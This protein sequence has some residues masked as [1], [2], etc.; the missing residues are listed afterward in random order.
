MEGIMMDNILTGNNKDL[1]EIILKQREG[2][3]IDKWEGTCLD[4]LYLIKERPDIANFAPGRIYN[5]IMK[6]GIEEVDESL[7]TRGY[8]DLV[9]YK[10]FDNRIYG[11]LEA[12]HDIMKFLKAA[13][14]RTETS[15]RILMMVGPVSSGKS[16]ISYWIKRGLEMDDVPVYTI[17]D[18]PLHEDPLHVIPITDRPYWNNIL[19]MKI[20]G[21]LC[22]VCLQRLK[23]EYSDERGN[24]RWEEVPVESF[25]FSEQERA[26]IGTF[27]PSDPKCVSGDTLLLSNL[28]ILEFSE[29][30]DNLKTEMGDS[31]VF[32]TVID[33]IK[34]IEKTSCFYNNGIQETLK[35][36]TKFGYEETLT[37][38]HP[39]LVLRDGT[40]Q[41]IKGKNLEEGDYI[42]LKRGQMMFGSNDDLP[43]FNYNGP[44]SRGNNV[45]MTF[46]EKLTPELSKIL[47]YLVSE[48]S[49][50]RYAMWFS[51]MNKRLIDDFNY[52]FYKVFNVMPKIYERCS[53]VS[54]VKLCS[55]LDNVCSIKHYSENKDI[56]LIIRRASKNNVLSFLEGLFWGDGT[57]STRKSVKSNR[58]KYGSKSEKLIKQ[59]QVILLN[60]GIVSSKG[61]VVSKDGFVNYELIVN[62]D[63]VIKLIDLIPSLRDKKTDDGN[64]ID[65]RENS[66]WDVLPNMQPI[67]EEIVN[68]V[69]EKKGPIYKLSKISKLNRYKSYSEHGRFPR[70]STVIQIVNEIE[71]MGLDFMDEVSYLKEIANS[72]MVWLKLESIEDGGYQQVYDITVPRTHSFCANGF[73][74]HNS[75]DVSELIGRVNMALIS[76]YGEDDPRGYNFNGEL[77]VANRGIIEY[78]EILKADAKLHYVLITLAQEQLI[79][80]PG[81][82]QMYIDSLIIS[83][84]NQTEFDSFRADKKNEALHDRIYEVEVPLNVRINDEVKIYEKMIRE[85]DF[86]DIHIAPHTLRIA[87]EFAVLSRLVKST[88][89]SSLVEKMK[90]YNG[91]R[92]EEFAKQ[93]VDVKSLLQEGKDSGEGMSG[94]SP[95]FIINALNIALGMKESKKCINPID[96]IRALRANFD[97]HIGTSD[98]DKERFTNI[99]IGEKESVSSEFKDIAKKEVN[100]AFLYAYEEQ[101]QTLFEN[102]MKSVTSFC[103]KEKV[104]DSITGEYSDP[105][106]KLMRSIEELASVPVNSKAEFRNS[107]FVHKVDSLERGRSFTYKDYPI[108]KESVEKKLIGDLK[109]LVSLSL[110]DTTATD[111]KIKKRRE[112]ALERLM[113]TGHCESCANSILSFVAEILRREG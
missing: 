81:F 9:R 98:E 16:T 58:F 86:R 70:R 20:E 44:N 3:S 40:L 112:K 104:L 39:L 27:A 41:W 57:I 107:I 53:S 30:Q 99:L 26:G 43:I 71:K 32:E 18:C 50:D 103:K 15:K 93:E 49:H 5:M 101:A 69:R 56:P 46:P 60:M 106:E 108:L 113:E 102:Y 80:A 82:P 96:V 73:I 87:A 1:R 67:F 35:I 89:V 38:E 83:H 52:N 48:G 12:I 2:R 4:Y 76:K 54:S 66:N 62:G 31:C 79:K 33:G 59:L 42:T 61:T 77:Q 55:Y 23:K 78:I 37:K 17:K 105:D 90:I 91:E 47:G 94:I 7:K 97:H 65:V 36:K 64:F 8:E 75:Q 51:N 72:D 24:V 100:R 11:T 109:N 29:I 28:G 45:N 22:P 63:D 19:G 110:G 74:N 68:K 10:F 88:K 85:S 6:Y 95:R 111:P 92:T 21:N 34:G 14:R 84:T 25:K 13:A